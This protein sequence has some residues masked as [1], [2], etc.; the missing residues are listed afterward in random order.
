MINL[1]ELKELYFIEGNSISDLCIFYNIS[2]YKLERLFEENNIK[3]KSMSETLKSKKVN[4][5]L[6]ESLNSSD[7][8]AANEKRK[9]TKLIKYGDENYCNKEKIKKTK[10]ERYSDENY[11]N[12]EKLKRTNLERHG[13]ECVF[14]S[15][16]VKSTIYNTN[17]ERYGCKN[18]Y[19]IRGELWNE[20]M[21]EKYG[22]KNFNNKDQIRIS[23]LSRTKEE[24]EKSSE[25]RSKTNLLKYGVENPMQ[26]E[27]I[28]RKVVDKI[29]KRYGGIGFQIDETFNKAVSNHFARNQ[30]TIEGKTY[31]LQGYEPIVLYHLI[32]IEKINVQDIE[33]HKNV[34]IIYYEFNNTMKRHFPDIYIKKEN[35]I[36]EVKGE[37]TLY[38]CSDD[39]LEIQKAK[40]KYAKKLGYTYQVYLYKRNKVMEIINEF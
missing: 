8:I 16:E 11:N 22:D 6:R 33:C 13:V 9:E 26:N 4:A 15:E 36:I 35:R 40:M 12:Q 1:E 29:K 10:L 24:I 7:K 2:R 14:Q 28:N 5:R 21:V 25:R 32:E 3:K 20:R 34:P 17:I 39:A 31:S 27:D 18:P 37:F 19:S 38:E 30:I 23:H